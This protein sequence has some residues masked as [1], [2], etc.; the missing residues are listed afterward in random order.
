MFYSPY[1]TGRL[2]EFFEDPLRL[3]PDRWN[4]ENSKKIQPGLYTAFHWGP[5]TCLGKEMAYVEARVALVMILK[6]FDLLLAD[7]PN[8]HYQ[9]SI[10]LFPQDGLL[11]QPV[12]RS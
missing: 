10:I 9:F 5:Q 3:D 7:D 11:M 4:E 12:P 1:V 2:P 6:R 8:K